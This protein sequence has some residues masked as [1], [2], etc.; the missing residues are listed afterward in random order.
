MQFINADEA[1]KRLAAAQGIDVLNLVKSMDDRNEE[2]AAS[3]Q[4]E[5]NMEL[6]KQ[7]GQFVNSPIADPSKNPNA[8]EVVDDIASQFES[9]E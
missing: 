8:E 2:A 6:T 5:Q 1:I 7:A 4:A 9:E 3:A